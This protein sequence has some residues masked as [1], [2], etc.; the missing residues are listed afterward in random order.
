MSQSGSE[1]SRWCPR[2][3][4]RRRHRRFFHESGSAVMPAG[5]I[6]AHSL[7]DVPVPTVNSSSC[8]QRENNV[9]KPRNRGSGT[10]LPL[11]GAKDHGMVEPNSLQT[12]ATATVVATATR[13]KKVL[14]T[15][16][17]TIYSYGRGCCGWRL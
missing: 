2:N 16:Q 1:R 3:A 15:A 7:V 11:R 8:N 17:I 12:L 14:Q 4:S 13:S 10:V 9:S 6:S 5:P